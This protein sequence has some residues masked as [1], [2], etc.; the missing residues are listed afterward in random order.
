MKKSLFTPS[1]APLSLAFLLAA[2]VTPPDSNPSAEPSA[3]PSTLPADQAISHL[4]SN[5]FTLAADGTPTSEIIV[6]NLKANETLSVIAVQS[7]QIDWNEPDPAK[8][9]QSFYFQVSAEGLSPSKSAAVT[10]NQIAPSLGPQSD[11]KFLNRRNSFTRPL[12]GNPNAPAP[13]PFGSC[14]GP[15]ITDETICHFQI[16]INDYDQ[17]DAPALLRYQSKRAAFFVDQNDLDQFSTDELAA[18]GSILDNNTL[19]QL[20]KFF[21]PVPDVDQNGKY[22]VVLSSLLQNTKINGYVAPWDLVSHEVYSASWKTNEGDIIYINTPKG[23]AAWGLSRDF[24]FQQIVNQTIAHETKHL[25]ASYAQMKIALAKHEPIWSEFEK[26]WIEEASA[27]AA[28]ELC[29]IG[30]PSYTQPQIFANIGIKEP[31]NYRIVYANYPSYSDELRAM[32][33]LDF[34]FLWRIAEKV[35]HENFWKKLTTSGLQGVRNLESVAHDQFG[36]FND[37]LEDWALTLRFSDTPVKGDL[38]AY[39]YLAPQIHLRD[40]SWAKL[41][42]KPL[43]SPGDSP[44]TQFIETLGFYEGLGNNQ[45]V[46]LKITLQNPNLKPHFLIVRSTQ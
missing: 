42:I 1:L 25:I 37:M 28:V 41:G 9:E 35:G 13:H 5:H 24:Y 7:D 46:R 19:P 29:N 31:W 6:P 39:D 45:D 4:N 43:L 12:P 23:V 40:G 27:V 10:V 2:C 34:L 11:L 18:I 8:Q 20:E 26:P 22:L 15:L 33:G 21:G 3:E 16:I 30:I 14:R 17:A 36:S 32:Y 38:G 44:T